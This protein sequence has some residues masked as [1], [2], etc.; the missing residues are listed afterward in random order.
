MRGTAGTRCG[1]EAARSSARLSML[2]A[3]AVTV[4]A[5]MPKYSIRRA[6]G[7]A[8]G[9]KK[10]STSP[11]RAMPSLSSDSTVARWLPW[12][13]STPLGGPVALAGAKGADAAPL[14]N[15]VEAGAELGSRLHLCTLLRVLDAHHR[16]L[17]V[18]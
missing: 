2:R 9:R 5:A 12:V 4:P 18:G 13:W 6:K 14:A 3:K 10:N 11:S 16:G 8:S 15:A 1:R 17:G 7:C